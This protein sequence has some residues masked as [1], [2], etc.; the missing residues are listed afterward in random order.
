MKKFLGFNNLDD[1]MDLNVRQKVVKGHIQLGKQQKIIGV[2]KAINTS[3]TKEG[4]GR[5]TD[6]QFDQLVL[7]RVINYPELVFNQ[8]CYNDSNHESRFF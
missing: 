5:L 3:E 2:F 8:L 4:L 1:K 6:N 7:T